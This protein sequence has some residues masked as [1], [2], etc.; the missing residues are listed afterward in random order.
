[1]TFQ[2]PTPFSI[3]T[4]NNLYYNVK[5][6]QEY[7]PEYFYGFKKFPRQIINRKNIPITDYLYISYNKKN[8]WV[9]FDEKSKK[10][11]LVINK[12]WVDRFYFCNIIEAVKPS[13]GT[14]FF[15]EDECDEKE[16]EMTLVVKSD[17]P[18]VGPKILYLQNNEKFKDIDGKILEIEVRGEQ[19][20]N[21][22][23]FKVK[24]VSKAFDMPNL[25][26]VFYTKN[27]NYIL[28]EDYKYFIIPT[29]E[30]IGGQSFKKYVYLTYKGLIRVLLLSRNK[31]TENF[32][33]WALNKLFTCQM[34][35][36]DE[37]EELV[38]EV[39]NFDIKNIRAMFSKYVSTFPCIYLLRFG[40]VK[41]LRETFDISP[42]IDGSL[43][44][45]KYGRTKDFTKRLEQH[46]KNYGKLNNVVIEVIFFHTIDVKFLS[47]AETAISRFCSNFSKKLL[48]DKYNELVVFTEKELDE[49]KNKY[50]MV[51]N[52]YMGATAEIQKQITDLKIDII[53]KDTEISC[54]QKD[55]VIL[56]KENEN[57]ILKYELQSKQIELDFYKRMK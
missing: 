50:R 7:K 40:L 42:E 25:L 44:V 22:I 53:K 43:F 55:I 32:Q 13:N 37:R 2:Q 17:Q 41:D 39:M 33:D 57:N 46:Q 47:E 10:A 11:S 23:F 6:L 48:L 4:T 20:R 38:A 51:G 31:N 45:Y 54:L 36:C 52:T 12:T 35:S 18:E 30:N 16:E 19:D 56:K 1:M 24:D 27:T 49:A 34:G 26:D 9:I 15:V 29:T 3:D 21:K 14:L 5:D 28:N 8:G